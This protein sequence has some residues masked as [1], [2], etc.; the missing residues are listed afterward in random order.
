MTT[1]RQ[2]DVYGAPRAG[3]LQG[4]AASSSQ[5]YVGSLG[6]V[7]D[8][9]TGGLIYMQAR[10]YDPGIG[11]FVSEDTGQN[12]KNWYAYCNDNPVNFMDSDGK[13]ATTIGMTLMII[14][15]ILT[16]TAA[17]IG[18]LL[19][20]GVGEA[21]LGLVAGLAIQDM[22]VVALAFVESNTVA[23][24]VIGG[25]M[26]CV[27]AAMMAIAYFCDAAADHDSSPS[28]GSGDPIRAPQDPPG[29]TTV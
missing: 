23:M 13:T 12:G 22:V 20:P 1:S 29:W 24:A 4:V 5:G 11:R 25:A 15:T 17:I 8:Q 9:S 6:H 16:I 2:Y 27:G 7:T 21:V 28:P 14:G 18:V 26:A 10:Y 3:T 19:V